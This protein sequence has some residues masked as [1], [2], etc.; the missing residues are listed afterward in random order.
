MTA[1]TSPPRAGAR[2]ALS[3]TDLRR[4]AGL[5]G[6]AFLLRLAFVLLVERSPFP[7]GSGS[8]AELSAEL[9]ALGLFSDPFFY[10]RGAEL[11]AAGDGLSSDVGV[12]TAQ[13]PPVF[14]ALLSLAY[15]VAGPEPLAGELLNALLGAL[16]VVVL[17]LLV[18]RMFGRAEAT[19]AAALL[20]VLPGQ[21]LWTDLL[22]AETL[23]TFLVVGTLALAVMLPRRP[24]AVVVLGVAIGIATLT[25]GEGL[26]LLGAAMAVWWPDMPRRELLARTAAL[27]AVAVLTIAPWTVRNALVMDAFIPLSTNSSTTLWSGHNPSARGYQSYA[28]PELLRG[29]PQTGKEREV[30]EGKLLRREAL[31]YMTS[32]PLRE[33]ELIPLKLLALNRGDGYALEWVNG[34]AGDDRPLPADLLTPIS[35]I[36]D[37][38][39]YLLLALTAASL[40]VLGPPLWR[41]PV[42]RGVLV[43]FAGSLVLYGFVY[44]GNYRYRAPL[45]PLMILVS[46]PLL[47]SVWRGRSALREGR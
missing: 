46:A 14:P 17:Y 12:P 19:V 22:L 9:S 47:V 42:V 8:P 27:A 11:L 39:Y 2:S 26:L 5:G 1:A 40:L 32:H 41:R 23:Y 15:R 4:A 38:S 3:S 37:S 13:W 31:E 36:A 34:G 45:E 28:P 20:A 30:E 18:R 21:I 35:V 6:I 33:L 29:I 43:L 7:D 44:Y 25:R 16:T 24:W 10:H